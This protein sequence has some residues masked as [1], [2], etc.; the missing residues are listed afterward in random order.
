MGGWAN[1]FARPLPAAEAY[2]PER[3][4]K[5]QELREQRQHYQQQTQENALKLRAMQEAWED[6]QR[7]TK[8]YQEHKGDMSKVL[9][10]APGAGIRAGTVEKLRNADSLMRERAA[11]TDEKILK[12]NAEHADRMLGRMDVIL[13]ATDPAQQAALYAK[14]RKE[15][16]DAKDA[17]EDT[18]PAQFPGA[19]ALKAQY[20]VLMGHKQYAEEGI[21]TQTAAR[22]KE[23]DIRAAQ[24]QSVQVEEAGARAANQEL[25]LAGRTAPELAQA[26]DDSQQDKWNDWRNSQ[27][28]RI[29]HLIPERWSKSN[30]EYVR[31]RLGLTPNEQRMAEKPAASKSGRTEGTGVLGAI[32]NADA[33]SRM[34]YRMEDK[35]KDEDWWGALPKPQEWT[36]DSPS[37]IRL[38]GSTPAQQV[39]ETKPT[40]GKKPTPGQL[41]TI[42]A[43]KNGAI[44]NAKNVFRRSTASV[45]GKSKIDS[46]LELLRDATQNA[47]DQYEDKLRQFGMDI[48]HLEYPPATEWDKGGFPKTAPSAAPAATPSSND[49][50]IKVKTSKGVG[51]IPKS[52]LDRLKALDPTLEVIR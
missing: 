22:A 44:R 8:L 15:A 3:T 49:E 41:N 2:S 16:I 37:K 20:P 12:T 34:Y 29:R 40:G 6:E 50:K 30:T 35:Y 4:L 39:A 52:S 19:D 45:L 27:A 51:L 7:V 5:L 42:E 10:A 47:Q 1:P 9:E 23:T 36:K 21:K 17:T 13:G 18:L 31:K 46:Q 32:D 33:Y 28:E 24:T 25:T 43:Q 14:H 48:D 38:L 11:Q 26:E